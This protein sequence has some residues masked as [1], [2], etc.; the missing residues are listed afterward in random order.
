MTMRVVCHAGFI[1]LWLLAAPIGS[2]APPSGPG[3]TACSIASP[4]SGLHL[5]PF[6]KKYCVAA[7]IPIA[8]SERVPD[9]ALRMAAEILSHMLVPNPPLG[10]R[11][12]AAGV[13][14][15]VIGEHEVT[16]DI[17]EY[18]TL[19]R[20]HPEKDYDH[21]TRGIAVV[22][23]P[24]PVT[25]GAEENLLCYPTDRYR[26]ENIF[27][28]EFS[29]TIKKL[30]V[31]RIDPGFM[32]RVQESYAAARMAGLWA[33]TYSMA[34]ADE[35]WAEGVESYFD[36][37]KMIERPNGIHNAISTREKLKDYDPMLFALIE[38]VFKSTSWRPHCP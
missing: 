21:R 27:V 14:I 22:N 12:R 3:M 24:V 8:S 5:P 26:G 23:P 38:G 35:Y 4:P 7:G 1:S 18:Q 16:S 25:S 13:R 30:G 32:M 6:Y 11:L 34:N 15:A 31:E 20:M 28:H 19:V 2:A 9:A 10:D 29:H 17:P 36:V 33:N 37:N